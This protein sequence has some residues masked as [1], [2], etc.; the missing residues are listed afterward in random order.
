MLSPFQGERDEEN[1]VNA[2]L[3]ESVTAQKRADGWPVRYSPATGATVAAGSII[4]ANSR[5]TVSLEPGAVLSVLAHRGAAGVLRD[6][7]RHGVRP[8]QRIS[9]CRA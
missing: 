1:I 3:K 2:I 8:D 5:L 9:L 6:D 4:L 7:V